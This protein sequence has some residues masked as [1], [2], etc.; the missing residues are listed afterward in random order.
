MQRVCVCFF[1]SFSFSMQFLFVCC[2][3]LFVRVA[4]YVRVVY[5]VSFPPLLNEHV[6]HGSDLR[7]G[8]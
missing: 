8:E 3:I 5:L 6:Q 2:S 7:G 1:F 4:I